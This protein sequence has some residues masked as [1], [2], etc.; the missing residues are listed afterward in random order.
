MFKK[1][2]FRLTLLF[3][4]VTTLILTIMSVFYLYT[5]HQSLYKN[6]LISFQSDINT[7]TMSLE[8]DSV[9]SYDWLLN[10]QNNY[11]YIFYLYD[12]GIPIRF[13]HDT[14]TESEQQLIED[15]RHYYQNNISSIT[16]PY[17]AEYQE[18][19][20]DQYGNDYYVNGMII[21]IENGSSE[22]FA[23]HSR[24]KFE[25]EHQEFLYDQ[26][27]NDYHVSGIT[28]PVEN[29]SI[30]I[31]VI[32]SL[33]K[34]E[35]QLHTLY[36]KFGIVIV[37]SI[38]ALFVFSWF[39]TKKLLKPILE[40]QERQSQFIAA[41][42][43][44]IGNPVNTILSALGAME[45][46]TLE[47]QREFVVIAG[48]ESKRLARLTNDLLTLARSD[49]HSFQTSFG[50]TELDT[51]VL[52]CYEAFSALAREKKI[53]LSV[54]LQDDSIVANNVDSER[55]K[56][57]IAI[58]L[59]NAISYTPEGG[60]VILNCSETTKAYCIEVADSGIGIDAALKKRIFD[61][62]YRADDSRTSKSHFGLGLSIAKEIVELHHGTI[63]VY[64]TDGGG[65]TFRV[66]LPK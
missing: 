36:F 55:V 57:V 53:K 37:I 34:I 64:D 1:V 52:E 28:I 29:G 2:H 47:Q 49:N 42:S 21:P 63:S 11:G 19:P 65:S 22:I 23:I 12:N 3:T 8:N 58:L 25:A 43:H 13:T 38:A 26:G 62:F 39:Y 5:S 20:Y 40:S 16:S 41:A 50:R 56:Q 54:E 61:R 46:G 51:L 24:S 4:I 66:T 15:I 59:D 7:F 17:T 35:A 48:K 44:E 18:F 6:A 33:S 31:F 10:L 32:H 45:K 30:E 14:K 60:A 9:I 27:G